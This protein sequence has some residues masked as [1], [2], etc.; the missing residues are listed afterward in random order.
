M[1]EE[2]SVGPRAS[3]LAGSILGLYVRLFYAHQED[4]GPDIK[5]ITLE[6]KLL[7]LEIQNGILSKTFD[8]E[9]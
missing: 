5:N 8:A 2:K 9:I 1:T 6:S 7:D 3:L 4:F